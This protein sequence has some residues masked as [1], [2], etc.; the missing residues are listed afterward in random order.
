LGTKSTHSLTELDIQ[1]LKSLAEKSRTSLNKISEN[2][3][4]SIETVQKHV[5]KLENNGIIKGYTAVVDLSKMGYTVTA[6]VFVQIE[7]GHLSDVEAEIAKEDNVLAVYDTTGD[8]DA[9]L[10]AKFK[11]TN[12]LNAFVKRLLSMRHVRRTVTN[13]A[14]NVLKEDFNSVLIPDNYEESID[15]ENV[16]ST[17]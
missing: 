17:A 9:V 6:V 14:F 4:I 10:V 13:V 1:L 2:L 8:Y 11:D 15:K 16:S 7:G 3:G 5:K 12:G